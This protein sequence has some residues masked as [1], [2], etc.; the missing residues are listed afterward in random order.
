[1]TEVEHTKCGRCKC[2]RANDLFLNP[3]GRRLKTCSTCRT[4]Y[5][6]TKCDYKCASTGNLN[7]HNKQVH[8]KIKDIKCDQCDYACSQ[9]PHMIFHIQGYKM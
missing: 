3:K 2:W 7:K 1:M 5:K 8:L 4:R 6:C 9:K